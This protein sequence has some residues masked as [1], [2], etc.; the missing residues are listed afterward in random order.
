MSHL[1]IKLQVFTCYLWTDHLLNKIYINKNV[2]PH[3]RTENVVSTTLLDLEAEVALPTGGTKM[4]L[5][6]S[7]SMLLQLPAPHFPKADFTLLI[8]TEQLLLNILELQS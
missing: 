8:H 3:S 4:V 2:A 6:T 1:Y 7:T 5:T